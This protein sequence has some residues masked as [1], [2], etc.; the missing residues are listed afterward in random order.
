MKPSFKLFCDSAYS[1][2]AVPKEIFQ[3][4]KFAHTHAFSRVSDDGETFY[5]FEDKAQ[6]EQSDADRFIIH[7]LDALGVPI[8]HCP[9]ARVRTLSDH[10]ISVTEICHGLVSPIRYYSPIDRV[11]SH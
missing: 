11:K 9:I 6:F 3:S 4:N 5:L 8:I 10:V 1:W 7:Y 2:L